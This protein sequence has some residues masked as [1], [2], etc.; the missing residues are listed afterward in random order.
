MF[1]VFSRTFIACSLAFLINL[2]RNKRSRILL[3]LFNVEVIKPRELMVNSKK[4]ETIKVEANK[5]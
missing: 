3:S 2:E 5:R 1:T 4:V